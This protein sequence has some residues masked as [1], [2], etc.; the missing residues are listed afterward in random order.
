VAQVLVDET[1]TLAFVSCHLEAHEGRDKFQTR[2]ASLT[3][4]FQGTK[5]TATPAIYPDV[6]LASHYCFVLGDLNFRTRYQGAVRVEEQGTVVHGLV[7]KS[8]WNQLYQ[9]DELQMALD[10]QYCL[11]GFQTPVCNFPPTFKLERQKGYTYKENRTP[12][13]TDRILWYTGPSLHNKIRPLVYEPIDEFATSDHKPI[14][15]AFEIQT[16]RPLMFQQKEMIRTFGL[17]KHPPTERKHLHLFLTDLECDIFPN[18]IN[19]P[20]PWTY[21][22]LVSSPEEILFAPPTRFQQCHHAVQK[23]FLSRAPTQRRMA[24]TRIRG[25]TA[26]GWPR[27]HVIQDAINP[28]WAED[29]LH[30]IL[31]RHYKDGCPIPLSGA[32]LHL[33]IFQYKSRQPDEVIGSYPINL[34]VIYRSLARSEALTPQQMNSMGEAYNDK[35]NYNHSHYSHRILSSSPKHKDILA[36]SMRNNA[37]ADD[38]NIVAMAINGPLLKNGTQTGVIRC[39]LDAWWVD[40]TL[41]GGGRDPDGNSLHLV[42]DSEDGSE[43]SQDSHISSFKDEQSPKQNQKRKAFTLTSVPLLIRTSTSSRTQE[44]GVGGEQEDAQ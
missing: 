35:Y 24:S 10:H 42:Q 15:G 36:S 17:F 6:A 11:V 5:P 14:R 2:C 23:W 7:A 38:D 43:H 30:C 19:T 22:C 33:F 9:A 21:A 26:K 13:Y 44:G 32:I 41:G 28:S 37:M 16:N 40:E 27:T 4:I 31:R 18:M 20:K 39:S 34:E 1:T 29:H 12:S 8:N 3:Q 25:I